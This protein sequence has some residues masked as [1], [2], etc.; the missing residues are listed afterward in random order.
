MGMP[1]KVLLFSNRFLSIAS[2]GVPRSVQCSNSRADFVR[3]RE[4]AYRCIRW[5][6]C[7]RS[8]VGVEVH[9]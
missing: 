6:C 1:M 9:I 2:K 4:R 7:A 8:D 3:R 5:Y